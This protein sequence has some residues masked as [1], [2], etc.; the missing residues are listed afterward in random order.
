MLTCHVIAGKVPVPVVTTLH[1]SV[2]VEGGKVT[3]VTASGNVTLNGTSPVTATDIAASNGV[4]HAT[5]SVLMP[6]AKP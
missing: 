4:I 6:P 2:T 1:V 5:G 3:I